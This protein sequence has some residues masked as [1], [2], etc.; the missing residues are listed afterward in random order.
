MIRHEALPTD[1]HLVDACLT[2]YVDAWQQLYARYRDSVAISVRRALGERGRDPT[3]VEELSQRVWCSLWV[4]GHRRLRAFDPSRGPLGAYLAALARDEIL[5]LHRQQRRRARRRE[6]AWTHAFEEQLGNAGGSVTLLM[7]EFQGQ[8]TKREQWFLRIVLLRLPGED[9]SA[10]LSRSTF[11]RLKQ[12]I[13]RK[14]IAFLFDGEAPP[15]RVVRRRRRRPP[16]VQAED[17]AILSYPQE[18]DDPP[19]RPC[20]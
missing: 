1:R 13:R 17:T 4:R 15:S 5:V 20:A 3:L 14:L 7:H 9:A 6:V 2:G 10:P 8:L 11:Y 19:R 16:P 12:S 18:P